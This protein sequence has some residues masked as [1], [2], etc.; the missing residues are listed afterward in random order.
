MEQKLFLSSLSSYAAKNL[1]KVLILSSYAQEIPKIG[2]AY[3][4]QILLNSLLGAKNTLI[5]ESCLPATPLKALS[6][7]SK[8]ELIRLIDLLSLHDLAAEL[9]Q[10]VETKILKKIY[11]LL[12]EEERKFLK[13]AM[14]HKDHFV[15]MKMGLDRWDGSEETFRTLLHRRGLARL[16][17][18]LSGQ[19]PN[20]IWHICHRL[21]IGRGNAL[22]KYCKKEPIHG[23][24]DVIVR[25][26]ETLL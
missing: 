14:A 21:D 2:K 15:L 10:I 19:D 23:V 12:S 3:L 7:L 6:A 16:G 8:T 13:G 26:V 18:A 11:S 1:A 22:F 25:Q 20:L 24:S 4:R 9:R 17:A 5:P